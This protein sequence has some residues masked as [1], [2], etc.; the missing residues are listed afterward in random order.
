M[1][2]RIRSI[3]FLA[4]ALLFIISAP[5]VVFYSLGWRIDW[6]HRKIIKTGAMYFKVWPKSVDIYLNGKLKKKTDFFFG[7]ALIENLI[8]K[9]YGIEIKKE[10]FQSWKKTLEVQE[11]IATEEKNIILIPDHPNYTMLNQNVEKFFFSPDEKKVIFLKKNKDIPSNWSLEVLDIDKNIKSY[12]I[13]RKNILKDEAELTNLKFSQD[14]KKILIETTVVSKNKAG[15]LS[16]KINYYI[17]D[18]QSPLSFSAL[19]FLTSKNE[20]VYFNPADPEKMF[21]LKSGNLNEIDLVKNNFSPSPLKNIIAFAATNNNI[22]YLDKSG[23]L[24]RDNFSFSQQEKLNITPFSLKNGM[25]YKIIASNSRIFL[26]E[27]NSLYQFNPGTENLKIISDSMKNQTVSMDFKK[28]AYFNDNEI[29][30]LFIEE[31]YGQPQR[32]AGEKL[33]IT[34]FSEKI[35]KVYWFTDDYLVF[36]SG[37]K[38]KAAEIDDRDRINI[39]DL[40]EYDKPDIF[41]SRASKKLYY[42]SAN[43]FYVS[44]RL[45]P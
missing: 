10:G 41:W 20:E 27:G 29:W 19:I 21:W 7:S 13:D 23:S 28:I 32:K 36:N 26:R 42:L 44:D 22:Y 4:F 45:A 12:L 9:R 5:T 6:T 38:I 25:D 17:L 2:H 11:N 37:N 15:G 3:L 39:F 14:S 43:N 1:T 33:F 35:D 31:N 16:E 18:L 34:R 24:F 40:G 8:P 30:V